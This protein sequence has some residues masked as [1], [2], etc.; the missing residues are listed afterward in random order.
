MGKTL[1]AELPTPCLI[2]HLT[3]VGV[4]QTKR[5][6]SVELDVDAD[7]RVRATLQVADMSRPL[8]RLRGD[9]VDGN[10]QPIGAI[11]GWQTYVY[12]DELLDVVKMFG[13]TT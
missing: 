12:A 4:R 8:A 7:P 11:R 1:P 9:T 2:D 13:G 3:F 6:D 5:V 10:N